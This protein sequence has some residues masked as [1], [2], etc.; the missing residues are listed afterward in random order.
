MTGD[1]PDMA[2]RLKAVLPARWF[3]DDNPAPVG[4]G[5]TNAP[6]LTA[7][8]TGL[9]NA[10][11]WLYA[12]LA[13]VRLQTRIG[14][15][16]DDFLDM[17]S[18]DYFGAMLPRRVNEADAAFRARILAELRRT[19]AT[20]PGL[21]AALLALTGRTPVIFEPMRA[22]DTGAWNIGPGWGM[23]GG[24]GSLGLPAQIFVT[25]YRPSAAGIVDIPGW[26]AG[27]WRLGASGYASLGMVQGAVTDADILDAVA[28]TLP[29]G[30]TAW[31]R[32][33]S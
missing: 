23:G 11:S 6:V 29:A 15:A 10:W 27:G 30:V 21:I 9:G 1:I 24:Y 12:M 19:R 28:T 4:N 20:R 25:A 32:I 17:I 18:K 13:Y 8:L 31:T 7:V 33:S 26:G 14:S 16:T 2:A 5:V 3:G 22:A